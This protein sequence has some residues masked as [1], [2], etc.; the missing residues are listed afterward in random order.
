MMISSDGSSCAFSYTEP[1]HKSE[2]PIEC[3][4]TD[5]ITFCR[6]EVSTGPAELVVVAAMEKD[7]RWLR[8]KIERLIMVTSLQRDSKPLLFPWPKMGMLSENM[9]VGVAVT[10]FLNTQP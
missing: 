7:R 4:T 8:Y 1:K 6:M 3:K 10:Q 2:D 5:S 9:L